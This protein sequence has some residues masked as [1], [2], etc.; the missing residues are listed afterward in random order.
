[1]IS[2]RASHIS[3]GLTFT[4]D[5]ISVA[6]YRWLVMRL[7]LSVGLSHVWDSHI[8]IGGL[9]HHLII[10]STSKPIILYVDHI[11]INIMAWHLEASLFAERNPR[12]SHRCARLACLAIPGRPE[13]RQILT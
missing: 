7:C 12:V 11:N 13:R 10:T 9:Y 4:C 8:H 5:A 2:A 3:L 6:S 1:M